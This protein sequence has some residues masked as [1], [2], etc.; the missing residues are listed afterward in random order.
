[1]T[2]ALVAAGAVARRLV[3]PAEVRATLLEA[4]GDNDVNRAVAAAQAEQDSVGGLIECRST[5]LPP[6]LGEPFFDS[7]ESLISHAVFS[8]PAVKGI[9]FGAGF[10]VTRMR[11]SQCTDPFLDAEGRTASNHAGGV[12]G[13]ITNG[14]ELVFR[15]AVKPTSSIARPQQTVRLS[16]GQPHVL[17]VEGRH[18]ACIALRMPVIVEAATLL[19]VADALLLEQCL[20][21][22]WAD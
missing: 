22:V 6:G 18:D 3:A 4:G 9:E 15:V 8:I 13:G 20:P 11:G 2:V 19:V 7:M 12:A 17:R 21:R 14:N 16:T 5:G 10:G 1:V